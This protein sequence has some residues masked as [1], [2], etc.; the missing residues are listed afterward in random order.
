MGLLA[1]VLYTSGLASFLFLLPLLVVE[2]RCGYKA[3]VSAAAAALAVFLI[4][5][6]VFSFGEGSVSLWHG[7]WLFLPAIAMIIGITVFAHPALRRLDFTPRI[8]VLGLLAGLASLPVLLQF[9]A[10]P[11]FAVLLD[12][13]L[14]QMNSYLN[15]GEM[16]VADF[17]VFFRDFLIGFWPAI[18]FLWL[19]VSVWMS[20]RWLRNRVVRASLIPGQV[21]SPTLLEGLGRQLIGT[22]LSPLLHLYRV[23]TY[24][25][26]PLLGSWSLLLATR[27]T[28]IGPLDALATNLAFALS[29]CYAVQ[30]LAVLFVKISR[31]RM[32]PAAGV[33]LIVLLVIT[34][35]GGTSGL[36]IGVGLALVGTLETWIPF[37]IQSKGEQP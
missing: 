12:A 8:M 7:F 29:V 15:T 2:G 30:G 33:I 26:W 24:L 9:A 28:A 10:W 5:A 35:V 34:A 23:P 36:V 14:Q 37:R 19:F 11:E 20:S 16:P 27:F 22:G 3:M 13:M 25:V 32:A 4:L 21:M 18:V 17:I 31:T 1:A 6:L